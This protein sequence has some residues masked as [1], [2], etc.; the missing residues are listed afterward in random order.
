M[1]GILLD[2]NFI[3]EFPVGIINILDSE[4][5]ISILNYKVVKLYRSLIILVINME[6][7]ITFDDL[8]IYIL[9]W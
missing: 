1:E 8:Y 5:I 3:M 9:F 4:D 2:Y 6:V 7:I